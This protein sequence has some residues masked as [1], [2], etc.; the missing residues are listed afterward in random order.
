[1]VESQ[2]RY[3]IMD[4][5]NKRKI[6]ERQSLAKLEKD[7]R[8]QEIGFEK[9]TN[10]K[11]NKMESKKK[12]YKKDYEIW[13]KEKLLRKE[14]EENDHKRRMKA[15]DEEIE[16]KDATYEEDHK[17]WVEMQ[18]K[19]IEQ[20]KENWKVWKIEQEESITTKKEI[21]IEIESG[22]SSL[23]EMSKEQTK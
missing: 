10:E 8:I 17:R 6:N 12:S 21:L 19:L 1:M 11:E 20:E 23:K 5:L 14:M 16:R 2:S 15:I 7:L 9:N 18:E 4:E 22:I 13:K 3:A